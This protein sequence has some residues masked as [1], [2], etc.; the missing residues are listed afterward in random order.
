MS[1]TV[2]ELDKNLIYR[3]N[4]NSFGGKRG[5][6][7]QHEY[8]VYTDRVLSWEISEEK[9]QSVLDKLHQKWSEILKY[10]AQHVSVMVAGPAKYNAR[11]LDKS[12]KILELSRIVK[13]RFDPYHDVTVYEDGYEE[14][15]NIGD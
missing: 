11:K 8:R 9:K 5:D 15:Y 13:T 1:V 14:R 12:D 7:S 6:I 2:K 3:A 4:S 10:E